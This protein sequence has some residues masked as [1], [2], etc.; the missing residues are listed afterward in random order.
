MNCSLV[1]GAWIMVGAGSLLLGGCTRS[2]DP[3]A[4]PEP[5]AQAVE[6]WSTV[7]AGPPSPP[8]LKALVVYAERSIAIA[9]NTNI[10]GGAVGVHAVAPD[11]TGA[12][13][14]VGGYSVVATGRNLYSPTVSL[15]IN[16]S[17]GTLFENQHDHGQRKRQLFK[18]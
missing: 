9:N 18:E 8:S 5:T 2:E 15:A 16:S 12:Q 7:D 11:V 13:L 14:S 10:T 4:P 3:V 1:L 6:A 17:V